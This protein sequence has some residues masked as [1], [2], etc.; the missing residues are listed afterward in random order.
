MLLAALSV[1]APVK[2]I[3]VNRALCALGGVAALA[4]SSACGE[5][6]SGEAESAAVQAAADPPDVLAAAYA[7][8][9]PAVIPEQ[10]ADTPAAKHSI[11]KKVIKDLAEKNGL[12][13]DE[14]IGVLAAESLAYTPAEGTLVASGAFAQNDEDELTSVGTIAGLMYQCAIDELDVPERVSSHIGTTR[15][16][17]GTQEDSWEGLEARWT[18]HP[19]SGLNI[20]IWTSSE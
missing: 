13:E 3:P 9:D 7:A 19:D 4:L 10:Y 11:Y 18:Y 1:A 8:C 6:T 15:A 14:W 20:T 17:D 16:L 2:G 12:S 5:A